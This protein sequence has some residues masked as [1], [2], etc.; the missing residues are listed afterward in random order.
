MREIY[1]NVLRQFGIFV[2]C[3]ND[4]T[5]ATTKSLESFRKFYVV[6]FFKSFPS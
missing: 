4:F 1:L 5:E 6:A 2:R 3:G